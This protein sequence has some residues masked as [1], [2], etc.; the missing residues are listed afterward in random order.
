MSP[1]VQQKCRNL[2]SLKR[3]DVQQRWRVILAFGQLLTLVLPHVHTGWTA[4]PQ[5]LGARICALRTL[6][7]WDI[8]RKIWEVDRPSPCAHI[9]FLKGHP[10]LCRMRSRSHR[11]IAESFM[12]VW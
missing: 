2:V 6:L 12:L 4:K 5:T 9:P 8:K 7:L 11:L 1:E 10:P 3:S